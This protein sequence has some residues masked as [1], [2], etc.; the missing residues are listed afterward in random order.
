MSALI[1]DFTY[2]HCI[3]LLTNTDLPPSVQRRCR[4]TSS[5]CGQGDEKGRPLSL[6]EM[7]ISA[8]SWPQTPTVRQNVQYT[9]ASR[10]APRNSSSHR[11][12]R[13]AVD[14]NYAISER[15]DYRL[16]SF[17]HEGQ[18]GAPLVR[19]LMLCNCNAQRKYLKVGER[20]E[21][22]PLYS[23]SILGHCVW[24]NM[25]WQRGRWSS[26]AGVRSFA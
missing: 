16:S 20:K 25:A 3:T 4:V 6:C 1:C 13:S 9:T 11:A 18:T 22:S 17:C 26:R 2:V 8:S 5:L 24:Q 10:L 23:S 12:E 19:S 14:T 21:V 15:S 7:I